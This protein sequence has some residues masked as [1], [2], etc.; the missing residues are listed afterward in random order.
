MAHPNPSAMTRILLASLL[1]GLAGIGTADAQ[2]ERR[3]PT[4]EPAEPTPVEPVERRSPT[5]EPT[6]VPIEPV[7]RRRPVLEAAGPVERIPVD[8]ARRPAPSAGTWA[9]TYGELVVT[10]RDDGKYL[11]TYGDN[12]I[13]GTLEDGVLT[14][15]WYHPSASRSCGET[16]QGTTDW[17]RFRFTYAPDGSSFKGVWGYCDDAPAQEWSGRKE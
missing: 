9:T 14:G 10:R 15:I 11:G 2:T 12:R 1:L 13:L 17:G 3:L 4:T 6:P 8:I 5:T 16:K 7:E